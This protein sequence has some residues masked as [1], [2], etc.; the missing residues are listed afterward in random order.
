[1]RQRCA[2][3]NTL[4][5]PVY[6]GGPDGD[7]YSQLKQ[8]NRANVKQLKV[9]WSFDTGE[10]GGSGQSAGGGA[11]ALC[12]YAD[13]EGGGAGCGDGR[14]E[15]E[16]RLRC[17]RG[18]QPARGMAYWTDGKERRLFAGVMNFLYCLDARRPGKPVA[19][20]GEGGTD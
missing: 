14:A 4:G 18:K 13:A 12:V 7:H 5:W 20:F 19:S 15:V 17:C 11:D 8:I 10:K 1:M 9:A 6:N 2:A 16:V 3:Q